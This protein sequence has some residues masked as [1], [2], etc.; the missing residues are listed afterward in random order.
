MAV[1]S[2][3]LLA[4]DEEQN[5]ITHP[6][7]RPLQHGASWFERRNARKTLRHSSQHAQRGVPR[8]GLPRF[9]ERVA[10][11]DDHDSRSRIAGSVEAVPR[12]DELRRLATRA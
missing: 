7:T 10:A 8:T 1:F 6:F 5:G 2:I 12:A 4:N 9:R 11:F 3:A